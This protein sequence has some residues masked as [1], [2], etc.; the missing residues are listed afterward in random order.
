[1]VIGWLKVGDYGRKQKW[2]LQ[3]G[4]SWLAGQ[5]YRL[6]SHLIDR[7]AAL[8]SLIA[9]FNALACHAV[10]RQ[11]GRGGKDRQKEPFTLT[12]QHGKWCQA[13]N[14]DVSVSS[15]RPSHSSNCLVYTM[16]KAAF[17]I[18]L[19]GLSIASPL[20]HDAA[21][22]AFTGLGSAGD[23][24]VNVT[25]YVMSRCPDAVR[26]SSQSCLPQADR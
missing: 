13:M 18:A 11:A 17:L 6:L 19:A 10:L 3:S 8:C 16:L 9:G 15:I 23:P 12:S 24:K 7:A 2:V 5:V 22:A 20:S 1:M 25:L 4:T 14:H 26:V 21:Q